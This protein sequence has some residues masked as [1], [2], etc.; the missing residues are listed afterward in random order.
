MEKT[1]IQLIYL[2]ENLNY[3]IIKNTGLFSSLAH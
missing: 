1:K 3:W 2:G